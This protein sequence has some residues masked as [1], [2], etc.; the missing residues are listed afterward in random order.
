VVE[1]P[2]KEDGIPL[3][4]LRYQ[5]QPLTGTHTIRSQNSIEEEELQSQST[6]CILPAAKYSAVQGVA[7]VA[8]GLCSIGDALCPAMS[9]QVLTVLPMNAS[10]VQV[11]IGDAGRKKG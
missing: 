10:F 2:F 11:C 4:A 6:V 5:S 9:P 8:P 7:T 1:L 3:S